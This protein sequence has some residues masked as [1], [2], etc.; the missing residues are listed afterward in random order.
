MQ[1]TATSVLDTFKSL[2]AY[3]GSDAK[4]HTVVNGR[5]KSIDQLAQRYFDVHAD[6]ETRKLYSDGRRQRQY[7]DSF[8]NAV[9]QV[10]RIQDE[11][12]YQLKD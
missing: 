12:I 8:R 11:K 4:L 1:I 10:A 3:Y 6:N 5:Q 9:A 2:R 7:N